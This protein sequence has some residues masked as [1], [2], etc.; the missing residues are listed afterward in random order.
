MLARTHP[1]VHGALLLPAAAATVSTGRR[2]GGAECEKGRRRES[3]DRVLLRAASRGK[4]G[5]SVRGA[6]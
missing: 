3:E 5:I 2:G 6:A 1:V 4:E